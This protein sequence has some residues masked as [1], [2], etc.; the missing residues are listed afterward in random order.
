MSR[1]TLSQTCYRVGEPPSARL[2]LSPGQAIYVGPS[3]DLDPHSGSVSCL[4]IGVDG[5]F[6]IHPQGGRQRTVRSAFIPPR[7][8]HQVVAHSQRMA[9]CYLDP[10]SVRQRG[11]QQQMAWFEADIGYGHRRETI[12]AR[13][14][15]ELAEGDPAAHDWLELA[16]GTGQLAPIDPRIR[17][18]M[19]RLGE[20][21][22]PHL[23]AAQLA[24][25]AGLSLSRFLHLFRQHTGTSLRRYRLWTRMLTAA[26]LLAE[27]RDLTAAAADAG[28]ASPSHFSNSFHSMFGLPPSH[29]LGITIILATDQ[30]LEST[31]SAQLH[32]STWA[33]RGEGTTYR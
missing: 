31:Q 12:L 26:M 17:V 13:H 6:T 18:A 23:S 8:P 5:D 7:R 3:L 24:H 33:A 30:P 10:G 9:F 21:G 15:I 22:G 27:R 19:T 14:A 1:R 32:G 4:A 29:L 20:P 2:W 16:S 11:C 28:F 25:D